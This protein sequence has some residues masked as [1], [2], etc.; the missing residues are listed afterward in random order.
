VL[1]WSSQGLAWFDSV[2]NLLGSFA[3]PLC[4]SPL[5]RKFGTR[6]AF[7]I[8]ALVSSL[9]YFIQGM[10]VLGRNKIQMSLVYG[11]G[12]CLLQTAPAVLVIAVSSLTSVLFQLVDECVQKAASTRVHRRRNTIRWVDRVERWWSSK[13]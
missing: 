4:V 9:A 1:G 3:Q 10:S 8:G 11:A 13:V 2:Y 12:V 6:R 5:L 7:E